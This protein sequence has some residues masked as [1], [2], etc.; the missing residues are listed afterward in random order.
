[1]LTLFIDTSTPRGIVAL[2]QAQELLW[3]KELP[4]GLQNSHNIFPAMEEAFRALEISINQLELVGLAVGPGSYTGIRVGAAAAKSIAYARKIPLVGVSTLCGFV[5]IEDGKF[6]SLI[7]AKLGG[8]YLLKGEKRGGFCSFLTDPLT[9]TLEGAADYL[10]D[11]AWLVT[12]QAEPLKTEIAKRCASCSAVW[13]ERHPCAIE[14]AIRAAQKVKKG[15][16]LHGGH[17]DLLYLKQWG[18]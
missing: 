7:D 8:V 9:C 11:A 17:A 6:V 4:F 5:P 10:V 14:Y 15:E 18:E 1:M 12:P 3:K 13:V 16:I 2:F